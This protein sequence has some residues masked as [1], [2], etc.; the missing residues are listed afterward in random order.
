M[1]DILGSVDFQSGFAADI[2][3]DTASDL[4]AKELAARVTAQLL[5]TRKNSQIM[6]LG[7]S[8]FLDGV[9]AEASGASFRLTVR[10]NQPQVDDLIGRI[11]GA[12]RS[13]GESMG[14]RGGIPPLPTKP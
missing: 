5:E 9:K 8:A 13:F 14:S 6:M 10:Y 1:K 11:R 12:L 3:I 7:L 2:S 4:D